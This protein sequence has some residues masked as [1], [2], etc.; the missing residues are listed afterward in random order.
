MF[1]TKTMFDKI[2]LICHM[3]FLNDILLSIIK[4]SNSSIQLYTTKYKY[5]TLRY[6]C[7]GNWM[8]LNR[9]GPGRFYFFFGNTKNYLFSCLCF[10]EY[11][12]INDFWRNN[13]YEFIVAI[14]HL[15]FLKL[16]FIYFKTIDIQNLKVYTKFVQNVRGHM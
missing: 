10:L 16:N 13:A 1:P 3:Y 2:N 4:V 7:A 8:S 15:F 12:K 9:H 11:H 5:T 6:S 14:E